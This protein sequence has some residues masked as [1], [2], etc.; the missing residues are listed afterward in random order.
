MRR[1]RLAPRV[2]EGGGK[3]AGKACNFGGGSKI[4]STTELPQSKIGSEVPI[5]DSPLLKAGAGARFARNVHCHDPKFKRRK[6]HV[7]S[8]Y[9]RDPL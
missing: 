7:L 6:N 3:I 2:Y 8:Q 4:S 1:R 5:F 9:S